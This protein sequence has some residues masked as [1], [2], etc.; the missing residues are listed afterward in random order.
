MGFIFTHQEV[1]FLFIY[2]LSFHSLGNGVNQ[3]QYTKIASCGPQQGVSVKELIPCLLILH[4]GG[5]EYCIKGT[6]SPD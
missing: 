6:V 3:Q 5:G 4:Q 1:E 2:F